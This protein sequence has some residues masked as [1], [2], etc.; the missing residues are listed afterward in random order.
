MSSP[1]FIPLRPPTPQA[2][3]HRLP[4]K[5]EDDTLQDTSPSKYII[6]ITGSTGVAGKVQIATSVSKALSCPLYQ[7]DSLHESSAKAASLGTSRQAAT[8]SS[9]A[10]E[11]AGSGPAPNEARY[12]RMWLSKMTR[13]GLLFPDESRPANQGFSGFGGASNST[14]TSRRGSVSSV[15]S[16]SSDAGASDAS[17]MSNVAGSGGPAPPQYVNKPPT[18]S[19][20]EKEALRRLNPALMVLTHPELERWHKVCIKKAVGEYRIGVLFVPLCDDD[21]FPQLRMLDPRMMTSFASFG[22]FPKP[23]EAPGGGLTADDV[24]RIDIDG[25]VETITDEIVQGAR[26]VMGIRS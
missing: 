13:T 11:E 16:A 2:M 10:S 14:S 8:T 22:S 9:T 1:P 21:D 7:G 4:D 15:A 20:P 19:L 5:S 26:D 3:L 24:L 12:Q 18:F 25:D 17:S 6:L 23:Q